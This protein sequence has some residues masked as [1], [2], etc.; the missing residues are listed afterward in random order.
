MT[1]CNLQGDPD[2]K[3]IGPV[4]P[5]P[6]NDP[7]QKDWPMNPDAPDEAWLMG[8]NKEGGSDGLGA[9]AQPAEAD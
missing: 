4:I 5:D 7:D 9:D 1:Q 3:D 2:P 6:W 8:Q